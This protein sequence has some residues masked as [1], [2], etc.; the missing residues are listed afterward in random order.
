MSDARINMSDNFRK[1]IEEYEAIINKPL[2]I[3]RETPGYVQLRPEEWFIGLHYEFLDMHDY[4]TVEFHIEVKSASKFVDEL[5]D[6]VYID[7]ENK[8]INPLLKAILDTDKIGV[9]QPWLRKDELSR[10]VAIYP[11]DNPRRVAEAMARFIHATQHKIGSWL[12]NR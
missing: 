3:F 12:K 11:N 1:V 4:L 2:P 9:S 8:K 5:R 10:L 6:W 7:E